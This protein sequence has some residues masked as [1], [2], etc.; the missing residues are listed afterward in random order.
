MPVPSTTP[1]AAPMRAR[2]RVTLAGAAWLAAT[3]VMWA[4]GL[5]KGINLLTLLAYW[6]LLLW[7]LNLAAAGRQLRQLRIRRWIDD[8]IFANSPFTVHIEVDNP[9]TRFH[10][11]LRVEDHGAQHQLI[12]FLNGLNGRDRVRLREE[13][14]LARRGHYVWDTPRLC[15]GYPFGLLESSMDGGPSETVVVFPA[16]G[17]L[18]RGRLRQFLAQ[19][20]PTLGRSRSRPQRHPSAQSEFHGLRDFRA[21]DSPRWIHWRSSARRGALMVREFE[22]YPSDN[23]ILIVEPWLPIFPKAGP[24]GESKDSKQARRKAKNVFESALSLAASIC[25]EWCR[26]KG[27]RLLLGIAGANVVLDGVTGRAHA[28]QTLERLATLQGAADVEAAPLV[29]RLAALDLPA[30]PVLVVSTRATDLADRLGQG[31]RRPAACLNVAEREAYFFYEAPLK[32]AVLPSQAGAK[33]GRD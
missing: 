15:S 29:N 31:L 3:G 19:S 9:D 4:V 26:Q 8:A 28:H 25:W 2:N 5:Y 23:L 24:E 1:A 6:M 13:V 16:L 27:D 14:T 30:A 21:G 10:L 32:A 33:Q 7:I 17:R 22:D 11:G 12:W 20:A 18:N